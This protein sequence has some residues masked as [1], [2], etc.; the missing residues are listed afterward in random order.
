MSLQGID[1]QNDFPNW[2]LE[3]FGLAGIDYQE[4]IDW[5]T[6]A[7]LGFG[8]Y[9]D[10]PLPMI[11]NSM[12]GL[13]M[14]YDDSDIV[15]RSPRGEPLVRTKMLEMDP[16]EVAY[17]LRTGAPRQ[18]AVALADDGDIYQWRYTPFGGFFTKL[19]S[20]VK[21]VAQKVTGG[22]KKGIRWVGSK[23]KA[24]IKKLPGGKYLIK[25]Y[26]K[27]KKVGMK[28]V[29][30]LTKYLGPLAKKVAPLA[31]LIP[32]YGV[33][34][35]AALYKIGAMSDT[36]KKYK[37]KL[38][39]MGRPKFSSGKQAR[40][41]KRELEKRAEKLKKKKKHKKE[42]RASKRRRKQM[43]ELLEKKLKRREAKIRKELEKKYRQKGPQ[44]IAPPPPTTSGLGRGSYWN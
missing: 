17:T 43:K 42:K 19:F 29:K 23:A 30:P 16:R 1:V 22:I 15:A 3:N 26:D 7:A 25:V 24:L 37:V 6:H 14:E 39:E 10:R 18:G 5:S 27:V 20:K 12:L 8:A 38:D 28:L 21:S 33:A 4:P 36:L 11:D 9:L 44:L 40:A 13:V 32:G 35:S 31:A 34:I 2:G 41:V